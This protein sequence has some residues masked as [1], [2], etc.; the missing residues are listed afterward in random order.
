MSKA[1]CDRDIFF[2]IFRKARKYIGKN[3]S[4][5]CVISLAHFRLLFNLLLNGIRSSTGRG[6]GTSIL[7]RWSLQK[8]T[9][10]NNN[11]EFVSRKFHINMLKCAIYNSNYL[12]LR[13]T[14]PKIAITA[15]L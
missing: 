14:S 13:G 12:K 4:L 5:Y 15:T 9:S 6:S 11:E 3:I 10:Y 2:P 1:D 8:L 7:L